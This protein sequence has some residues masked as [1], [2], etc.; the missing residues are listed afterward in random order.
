MDFFFNTNSKIQKT[1]VP[2]NFVN[3]SLQR[4]LKAL[5]NSRVNKSK[6]NYEAKVNGKCLSHRQVDVNLHLNENHFS[7][8]S[9]VMKLTELM[10]YSPH[11][12]VNHD[13][14]WVI[15]DVNEISS[16][17]SLSHHRVMFWSYTIFMS[18]SWNALNIRR[19][20]VKKIKLSY[21]LH[22]M[23]I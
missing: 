12:I 18:S 11:N 15:D 16:V 19:E 6:W 5:L 9:C 20:E 1:L 23:K 3:Y 13:A 21:Q 7:R 14:F 2:L 10:H 22:K 8:S 17:L 4:W